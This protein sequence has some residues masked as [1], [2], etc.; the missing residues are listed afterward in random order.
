MVYIHTVG[1]L[2]FQ[3]ILNMPIQLGEFTRSIEHFLV[4]ILNTFPPTLVSL[5]VVKPFKWHFRRNWGTTGKF[6]LFKIYPAWQ[7][8]RWGLNL[9]VKVEML[10]LV[11]NLLVADTSFKI[12]AGLILSFQ[13]SGVHSLLCIT[14]TTYAAWFALAKCV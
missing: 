2:K 8:L 1:A 6:D 14:S 7:Y 10:Q 13:L 12:S 11:S 5:W 9:I 4:L 3:F